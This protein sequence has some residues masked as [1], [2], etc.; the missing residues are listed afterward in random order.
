MDLE[1]VKNIL[2]KNVMST[3][4]RMKKEGTT[5]ASKECL[6]ANTS[7]Y[8]LSCTVKEYMEVWWELVD[9][10]QVNGFDIYD[11]E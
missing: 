6:R 2:R 1:E 8:G 11:D 5:G 3:I 10:L 7:T 9:E 4:K